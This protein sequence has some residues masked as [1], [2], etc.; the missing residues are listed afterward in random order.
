MRTA[1]YLRVSSV[2][3]DYSNQLPSILDYCK[4]HWWPEPEIYAESE[5]AWKQGHQKELARLLDDIRSGRRKYDILICWALDRLSRGG[6][7]A[8]LNLIN[9]FHAYGV[10][11]VS[12]QEPWT[13]LPGELGEVLFSIAG[14][15]ARMESQRRSERTRAG[16]ARVISQGQKLGRP[17]GSK[18]TKQRRRSGYHN[19]WTRVKNGAVIGQAKNDH[20]SLVAEG[21]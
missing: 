10:K 5:S 13:E 4:A 21:R 9:A 3:Q 19:R 2:E 1:A 11:V 15:S 8:I 18:D 7:A 17:K 6:A 12:L 14:W 20:I 16:L